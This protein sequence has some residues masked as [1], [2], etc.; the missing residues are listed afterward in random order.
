MFVFG[1]KKQ[2]MGVHDKAKTVIFF[3]FSFFRTYECMIIIRDTPGLVYRPTWLAWLTS[4]NIV[5]LS[6]LPSWAVTQQ[7]P[8]VPPS[9]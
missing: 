7:R 4:G 9:V 1:A 8:V 5:S 6:A 3:I 2:V